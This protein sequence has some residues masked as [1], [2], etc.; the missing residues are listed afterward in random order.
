MIVVRHSETQ[1][2]VAAAVVVA[3]AAS[4]DADSGCVRAVQ[5]VMMAEAGLEKLARSLAFA[6]TC[7]LHLTVGSHKQRHLARLEGSGRL[8]QLEA[9]EAAE[10]VSDRVREV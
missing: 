2:A 8:G 6:L 1:T 4:V 7:C 10:T 3:A 5:P 9:E